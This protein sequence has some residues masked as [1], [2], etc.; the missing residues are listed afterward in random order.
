MSHLSLVSS[1]DHFYFQNWDSAREINAYPPSTGAYALYT[2][3][4]FYEL[5][6]YASNVYLHLEDNVINPIDKVSNS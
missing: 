6:D 5:F 3:S 4:N 2:R 1:K